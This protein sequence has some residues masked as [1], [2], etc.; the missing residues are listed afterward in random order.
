[1]FLSPPS[2]YYKPVI[3]VIIKK[4]ELT[5][6]MLSKRTYALPY[7]KRSRVGTKKKSYTTAGYSTPERRRAR[8]PAT[9]IVT[10]PYNSKYG[11]N[12]FPPKLRTTLRYQEL[13]GNMTV[14]TGIGS[15]QFS[16]NGLH[17]PNITQAGH[18]PLYYDQLMNIYAHYTVEYSKI[19]LK[20]VSAADA[21][22]SISL[23]IDEDTSITAALSHPRERAGAVTAT[24][25]NLVDKSPVLTKDWSAKKFFGPS[26]LDDKDMQGASGSNPTEQ[27][28][29]SLVFFDPL[30]GTYTVYIEAFIEYTVIF[31]EVISIADS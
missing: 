14:T 27:S 13:M 10:I 20:F 15:Y 18:Q 24:W 1:M 6:S 21:M 3:A 17:D 7:S 29:Y 4:L 2:N 26:A 19:R 9:N 5:N 22:M 11:L 23:F 8:L 31:D 30:S 12:P 25:H 16:C 28:Y